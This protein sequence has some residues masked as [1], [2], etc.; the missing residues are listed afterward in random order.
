VKSAFE[1]TVRTPCSAGRI[2]LPP[3][4]ARAALPTTGVLNVNEKVVVPRVHYRA[5][6]SPCG[7]WGR[8]NGRKRVR[9]LWRNWLIGQYR[10]L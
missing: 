10:R 9:R 5:G 2:A 8:F 3:R 4:S 7:M 6:D 1:Q